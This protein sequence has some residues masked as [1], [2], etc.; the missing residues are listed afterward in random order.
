MVRL[1]KRTICPETPSWPL[2]LTQWCKKDNPLTPNISLLTVLVV[3]QFLLAV[4]MVVFC[5]TNSILAVCSTLVYMEGAVQCICAISICLGRL[6]SKWQVPKMCGVP[7]AFP[8]NHTPKEHPLCCILAHHRKELNLRRVA[9]QKWR[10]GL[11]LAALS[12]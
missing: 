1:A 4:R 8:F 10:R 3:S 2:K 5:N 7:C 6:I 9:A 12:L 11:K